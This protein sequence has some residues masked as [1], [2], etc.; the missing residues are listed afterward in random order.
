VTLPVI[1]QR[2][3]FCAFQ[4]Q[5]L[6]DC[7]K[8]PRP[9]FIS[10]G[11]A[12]RQLRYVGEYAQD[13]ACKS[14]VV[15]NH[16]IDR[17]YMEDHSVFYSKNLYPY[18]NACRRVHFFSA[19][20]KLVDQRLKDILE[21]GIRDGPAAYREACGRFSDEAYLGFSVI[22]PL[23]GSPVGRTVLRSFP[24]RPVDPEDRSVRNFECTRLYTTHLRG[25]E[26]TVRGL[27]FQQQ[28]VGVSACATTAV[29]S[30]LQKFRDHEDI[31][32]ATPAQIT[33]LAAKYSLPF[34]RAMPSEGLSLD[35][36]CQAVQAVGVSPHIFRVSRLTEARGYLYSAVRSGLAPV[37]ILTHNTNSHAVVVAGMKVRSP[38][39][40]ET[41]APETDDLAGDV[42]ALY[43]HDDRRGPYLRANLEH[44]DGEPK[45]AISSREGQQADEVWSLTHILVPMHSKIR[46]AVSG[47]RVTALQIVT[48]MHRLREVVNGVQPGTIEDPVVAFEAWI[49]RAHK[50]VESLFVGVQGASADPIVDLCTHVGMARYLGIIRLTSAYFDP[51]DVLIDTTGTQRNAHC[52]GIVVPKKS[53]PLTSELAR[54]LSLLYNCRLIA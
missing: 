20:E 26:L 52:L 14:I 53:R 43:I 2:L 8:L 49:A 19:G 36:M 9:L 16:Y 32:A 13:L 18:P 30:A 31:A 50:Y 45:L 17:D 25:V 39:V 3:D 4:P 41:V 15:E 10:P 33:S 28:D 23:P 6:E 7:L 12:F 47:L 44:K 5:V 42:I 34:G 24:K 21:I 51:I 27:A 37:L 22:K 46:L 29:W 1:A 35:Q 48:T 40:P 38:H 11:V 54:G